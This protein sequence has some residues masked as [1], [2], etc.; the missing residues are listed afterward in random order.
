MKFY[1]GTDNAKFLETVNIPWFISINRLQNRVSQIKGKDWILDSGGFTMIS[2]HGKYIISPQEYIKIIKKQKP[3]MAFCQDWMCEPHIINKTGLSIQEH[4]RKTTESYFALSK[5]ATEIRP[6]LQGWHPDDYANHVLQYKK[7]GVDMNQLFGIGTICSRS[8]SPSIIKEILKAIHNEHL[9]I[10][11]HA[12]GLKITSLQYNHI[13]NLIESSDSM[14]WSFD[15]RQNKSKLCKNCPK[16]TCK[17]CLEYAL[18]WRRN[19]L[20]MIEKT[21][22]KK[23]KITKDFINYKKIKNIPA[24]NLF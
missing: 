22:I 19:L 2:N 20:N 7:A 16:K 24:L 21:N 14:S 3:K 12:F 8:G 6:V 13:V 17:H 11:L 4:Q 1:L 5:M 9:G 23:Y 18:L 15:A 10:K